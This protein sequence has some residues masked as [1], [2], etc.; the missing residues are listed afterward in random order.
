MTPES[1]SKEFV[2]VTMQRADYFRSQ[3]N[4]L[5]EIET[6]ELGGVRTLEPELYYRAALTRVQFLNDFDGAIES[7]KK[8]CDLAPNNP[9]YAKSLY[10]LERL[11]I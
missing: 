8:A 6:L 4:F 11:K 10:D 2:R 3:G 1:E 9:K 7:M 5:A